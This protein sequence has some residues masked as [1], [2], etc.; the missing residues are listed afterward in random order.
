[1]EAGASPG[2]KASI[3]RRRESQGLGVAV[4]NSRRRVLELFALNTCLTYRF[5]AA[6]PPRASV[7]SS[8]T[9]M[10]IGWLL[11]SNE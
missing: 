11:G 5:G 4:G 9:G 1:M 7:S 3:P 2:T 6:S 10:G 8:E